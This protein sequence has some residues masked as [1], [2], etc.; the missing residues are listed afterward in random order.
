MS[1]YANANYVALTTPSSSSDRTATGLI[2]AATAIATVSATSIASQIWTR[3]GAITI[4]TQ[5]WN[6]ARITPIF[7]V[8]ATT[9][10]LSVIGWNR[11][12]GFVGAAPN[13]Y[14]WIP[15]PL[16]QLTVTTGGSISGTQDTAFGASSMVL[17]QGDAKIY[18]AS[19]YSNFGGFVV[20]LLGAEITSIIGFRAAGGNWLPYV[21][22]V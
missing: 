15:T 11:S 7:S 22:R 14:L 9:Y 18:N 16:C 12:T 4:G 3:T 13:T 6:Y 17:A 2:N 8:D 21:G 20:D 1:H 5:G 19:S 10:T